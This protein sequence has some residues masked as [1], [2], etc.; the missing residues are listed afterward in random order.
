MDDKDN[1]SLLRTVSLMLS[2]IF[3]IKNFATLLRK[4]FLDTLSSTLIFYYDIIIY[5][6][7]V[8]KF[9]FSLCLI[10]HAFKSTTSSN[11]G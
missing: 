10:T 5:R 9:L 3:M 2:L 1:S 4:Y 6:I 7:F 11:S 8:E